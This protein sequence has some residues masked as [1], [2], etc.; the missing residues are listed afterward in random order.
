MRKNRIVTI[1][2]A[3]AMTLIS[4]AAMATP[5]SAAAHTDVARWCGTDGPNSGTVWVYEGHVQVDFCIGYDWNHLDNHVRGYGRVVA[6]DIATGA[7]VTDAHIDASLNT[8]QLESGL[9]IA[10]GHDYETNGV[11]D[12]DTTTG[13]IGGAGYFGCDGS[14]FY[15]DHLHV[16]MR[17][18]G[19][20]TLY[21]FNAYTNVQGVQACQLGDHDHTFTGYPT[22]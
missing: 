10:S 12:F 18:N 14:A 22:S 8:D 16:D 6:R 1:V 15:R 2:A 19:D 17:F 11:A 7:T 13:A 21:S 4:G 5:A 3:L 9:A 20:N